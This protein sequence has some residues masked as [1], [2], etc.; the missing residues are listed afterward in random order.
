MSCQAA[1]KLLHSNSQLC[2]ESFRLDDIFAHIQ[3]CI[4]KV[5]SVLD[6]TLSDKDS[7]L[8][9][10][11]SLLQK[12]LDSDLPLR[13]EHRSQ[14]PDLIHREFQFVLSD[15]SSGDVLNA[16]KRYTN[17]ARSL[18]LISLKDKDSSACKAV[19][20]MDCHG[21]WYQA[22]VISSSPKSTL[23]HFM[24]SLEVGIYYYCAHCHITHFRSKFLVF[25]SPCRDG[26]ACMTKKFPQKTL[27]RT[28]ALAAMQLLSG[29][30]ELRPQLLLQRTI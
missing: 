4:T 20:A 10:P 30:V 21:K 28:S 27:P 19:D 12:L 24:V 26:S 9:Q 29:P 6:P 14:L 2:V 1:T 5:I 11:H 13:E 7:S 23:V 8:L 22:F 18:P 3:D 17:F 25:S 16:R 15:L